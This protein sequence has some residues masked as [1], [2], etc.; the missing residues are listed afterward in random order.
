KI[1][2]FVIYVSI[3]V[4][5]IRVIVEIAIVVPEKTGQLI[6]PFIVLFLFM[7]LVCL[8]LYYLLSNEVSQEQM[9]EPKNPAQ[10]K[11][12]FI[13]GI[14]YGIILLA[15]AFAEDKFGDE[16]LYFISIIGG[17]AKKDAITLS[18]AQS[19]KSGMA[20]ELG[21]RLIMTGTLA[22]FAF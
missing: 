19:I 5:I 11:S 1:S 4:S 13:F 22:N 20:T 3:T 14:L 2:A 6:S 10:F 12:A 8:A 17:L 18:L 9:P 16:G 15:V 7:C 21:W